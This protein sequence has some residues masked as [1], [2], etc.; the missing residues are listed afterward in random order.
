MEAQHIYACGKTGSGKSTFLK[1]EIFAEILKRDRAIVFID[2]HGHDANDLLDALPRKDF[3][4]TVI[5]DFS[6]QNFIVSFNPLTAGAVHTLSGLKSIWL[7]SWGARMNNILRYALLVLE[8]NPSSVLTDITQL[9]HDDFYR[10]QL[11]KKVARPAVKRFFKPGGEF[12]K[13]YKNARDHPLSPILNKIGEIAASDISRFLCDRQPTITFEKIL[14]EKLLLIVNLSKP[15]LGDEAAAIAGSLITTTL[16][17]A[18]LRNPTTCSLYAD[19]F[20]TYGT[21]LFASMLSEMRKFGLKMVLTHQ[22]IHQ[23]PE[24]LQK[25]ILGNVSRRVIFNVDY[26]DAESPQPRGVFENI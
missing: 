18:L 11:L 2:P 8:Q 26:E 7:E 25:A 1:N 22:F 15:T 9:L 14:A 4:R 21:A 3:H 12:E 23:V 20:Q 10:A 19:E 5:L 6:D 17:A 24:M 16:R 13:E